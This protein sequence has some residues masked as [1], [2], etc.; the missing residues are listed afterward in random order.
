[1]TALLQDEKEK[2]KKRPPQ[3]GILTKIAFAMG[4]PLLFGVM[5]IITFQYVSSGTTYIVRSTFGISWTADEF[6]ASFGITLAIISLFS[7]LFYYFAIRSSR[8]FIIPFILH[9]FVTI[10]T[11]PI[12]IQSLGNSHI[13]FSSVI[14]SDA[15][16]QLFKDK[17]LNLE[18]DNITNSLVIEQCSFLGDNCRQVWL[19][20]ENHIE[21]RW[22]FDNFTMVASPDYEAALRITSDTGICFDLNTNLLYGNSKNYFMTILPTDCTILDPYPDQ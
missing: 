19:I 10:L 12:I 17:Q 8:W 13:L 16:Y 9:A 20:G 15:E 1:M 21:D 22:G 4:A 2:K 3:R 7:L 18:R 5:G 6:L 14:L 11:I